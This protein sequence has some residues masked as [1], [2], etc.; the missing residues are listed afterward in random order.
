LTQVQAIKRALELNGHCRGYDPSCSDCGMGCVCKPYYER[1]ALCKAWLES[2]GCNTQTAY[3]RK[4][5]ED[6]TNEAI[7][8]LKQ[9]GG[10]MELKTGHYY[11]WNGPNKRPSDWNYGGEMDFMLDGKPHLCTD[12]R[13]KYGKFDD[14]PSPELRWCWD[15]DLKY[16]TD[17]GTKEGNMDKK[18]A[19]KRLDALEEYIRDQE[20]SMRDGKEEAKKLREIIEKGDKIVYDSSK[21]YIGMYEEEPHLLTGTGDEKHWRFHSFDSCNKSCIG[22]DFGDGDE[23]YY[24]DHALDAGF[25]IHVFDDTKEALQFFIDHL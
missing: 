16:M 8:K 11:K 22:W 14:S 15:G 13:G 17:C 4:L 3:L 6:L 2:H 10:N 1:V 21:L 20:N 7:D 9:H 19:I 12:G 23:Q 5:V 24:I 18:A 25:D